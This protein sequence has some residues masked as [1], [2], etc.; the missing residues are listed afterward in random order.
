MYSR[1]IG[2]VEQQKQM[3]NVIKVGFRNEGNRR[4]IFGELILI[5][6]FEDL[7]IKK[8]VLEYN[9]RQEQKTM[10]CWSWNRSVPQFMIKSGFQFRGG[11]Q[12]WVQLIEQRIIEISSEMELQ[13]DD[14]SL[15]SIK[16]VNDVFRFI[17][18]RLTIYIDNQ[19]FSIDLLIGLS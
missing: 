17:N 2:F 4:Q 6:I 15:Q 14:S 5:K 9:E 8:A 13:Y 18:R 16:F 1:L 10:L 12:E 3:R 11:V 19:V 7:L